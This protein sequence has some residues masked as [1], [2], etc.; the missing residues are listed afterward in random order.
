MAFAF[1]CG[2]RRQE[3]QFVF[4]AHARPLPV[5][6]IDPVQPQWQSVEWRRNLRHKLMP[7]WFKTFLTVWFV[8]FLIYLSGLAFCHGRI[9]QEERSVAS[10]AEALSRQPSSGSS[11]WE[12]SLGMKFVQ[13]GDVLFGMWETRVRD[14]ETFANATARNNASEWRTPGFPQE[15]TY[16]VV[17]VSWEDAMAF[18]K[19]LTKKERKEG[20]LTAHQRYRLPT[21]AEW[22]MAAGCRK[23]TGLVAA[24]FAAFIAPVYPWGKAWPPPPQA[25]NYAV[26]EDGYRHTS[27]VGSFNPNRFGIHDLAGNVWEW[28]MDRYGEDNNAHTLRGGAWNS[29]SQDVLLSSYRGLGLTWCRAA[30]RG[31]RCVIE[32]ASD[33]PD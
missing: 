16:P 20:W 12:N 18:C 2:S 8:F 7:R 11:D 28:C 6:R 19:W 26:T 25:G 27:P 24:S 17:C 21:D 1:V 32:G 10:S 5:S 15:P 3:I 4:G 9:R 13:V 29:K 33:T 31:F 30:D 23:E 14:F 22:S